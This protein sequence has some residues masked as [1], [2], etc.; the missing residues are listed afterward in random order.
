MI[1]KTIILLALLMI[2]STMII[3]GMSVE[4]GGN[5]LL[6][7]FIDLGF[8]LPPNL[9]PSSQMYLA[10]LTNM[11]F[12]EPLSSNLSVTEKLS[13]FG[14][15]TPNATII[16]P[17]GGII[18][19]RLTSNSIEHTL[20]GPLKVFAEVDGGVLSVAKKIFPSMNIDVGLLF[21]HNKNVN[22]FL[23]IEYCTAFSDKIIF[24]RS[25][26]SILPRG[27]FMMGGIGWS[28]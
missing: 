1:K 2:F 20:V 3:F 13:A 22:T 27:F 25:F 23:E 28:F 7:N 17:F 6:V 10:A 19:A 16:V 4:I 24:Q 9:P 8:L 5:P 26:N 11:T 15:T 12:V 14:N 21:K 18:G